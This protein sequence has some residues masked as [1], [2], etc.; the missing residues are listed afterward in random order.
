MHG[1]VDALMCGCVDVRIVW[2]IRKGLFKSKGLLIINNP[3]APPSYFVHSYLHGLPTKSYMYVTRTYAVMYNSN[4]Q[5]YDQIPKF[6]SNL[7]IEQTLKILQLYCITQLIYNGIDV[8][9][10]CVRHPKGTDKCHANLLV[11]GVV[12]VST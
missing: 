11:T 9:L 4:G 1:Y 3:Q 5:H 2:W 10:C 7:D 12:L 6:K 8:V